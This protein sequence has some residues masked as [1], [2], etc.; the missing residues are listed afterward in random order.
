EGFY[1]FTE[2]RYIYQY[3]DHLGNTRVSFARN[4][5][6]VLQAIDTN[7]YYP[8]GLNHIGGSS[9]SSIGSYNNYKYNGKELQETG[10][11][12]YGA[13]F[14]MPDIGRWGVVDPLAE[15]MTRHS[16][17]NYAFNNPLRFIDPDGRQGKDIFEIDKNGYLHN[18]GASERDVVYS[19]SNFEGEGENRKLKENNDK[20]VDVGE[21]GFIDK[22]SK[23]TE[24]GFDYIDFG[25]NNE[26]T[27]LNYFFYAAK[28][29]DNEFG[30]LT[31]SNF[32]FVG[33][34][35][36]S[37]DVSGM[38]SLVGDGYNVTLFGHSHPGFLS[39]NLPISGPLNPSGFLMTKFPKA[40][41]NYQ[42]NFY[43]KTAIGDRATS[44]KF[45]RSKN[46]IYANEYDT[47]IIYNSET[48]LEAYG[49]KFK[50]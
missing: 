12:D 7:N 45:P 29:S 11:Y 25:K 5:A 17:Y 18:R 19:S 20:G 10:M 16:P 21:K 30:I 14:Y 43:E 37:R 35:H 42:F 31:E 47:T 6:G 15:K 50:K 27:A 4:S 3:K 1:S 44:A 8:F 22:N 24:S 48:I 32:T 41:N 38:T 34:D 26:A 23:K 9:Y 39:K 13:R 2:N 46:F 36:K 28:S 40:E 33:T 49:G